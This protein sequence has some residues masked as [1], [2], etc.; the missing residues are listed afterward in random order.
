MGITACVAIIGAFV[1]ALEY[2]ADKTATVIG[3][4]SEQFFRQAIADEPDLRVE[5]CVMI[6]DVSI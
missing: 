5:D 1:S 4:P 2:S 6:G 3:K